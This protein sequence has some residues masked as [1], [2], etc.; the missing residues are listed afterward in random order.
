M[1]LEGKHSLYGTRVSVSVDDYLWALVVADRGSPAAARA[2]M[3]E[4]IASW[5]KPNSEKARRACIELIARPEL[6]QAVGGQFGDEKR[7]PGRSD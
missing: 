7:E 4:Q 6:L 1:I 3:R 5:G 2:W